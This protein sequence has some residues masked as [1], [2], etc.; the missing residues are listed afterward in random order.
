MLLTSFHSELGIQLHGRHD[1]PRLILFHRLQNL[2]HLRRHQRVHLPCRL[3]VS[4][5]SRLQSPALANHRPT[6]FFYPETAY[7]SL[8]EMDSIFHKTR[9][10]FSVVSVAKNEPLRFGKHGELLINYEETEEHR[11]RSVVSEKSHGGRATGHM[12]NGDGEKRDIVQ[13]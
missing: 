2:R 6:D 9:S 1:H 5:C 10:I 3:S 11:R 13:G 7:R 4:L 8:E 12:E